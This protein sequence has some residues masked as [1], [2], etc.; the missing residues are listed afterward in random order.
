MKNLKETIYLNKQRALYLV[1][2]FIVFFA[3]YAYCGIKLGETKAFEGINLLFELDCPLVIDDMT[4]P[5]A[6]H[7]RTNVHPLYVIFFNPFGSFLK[8]IVQ[9]KILAATLIN[10]FTG[11]LGVFLTSIFFLFFTKNYFNSLLFGCLFGLSASQFFFGVI[12]ETF[13]ANTVSLILTYLLFFLCLLR[14]KVY[15]LA[16]ILAGVFT[17]GMLITNFIQTL[18]LFVIV[19]F[20][21]YKKKNT[22]LSKTFTIFVYLALVGWICTV[23]AIIQKIL[24]PTSGLFFMAASIKDEFKF[25]KF[26]VFEKP[27]LII[28]QVFRYFFWSNFIAPMPKTKIIG[29]GIVKCVAGGVGDYGYLGWLAS[30]VGSV[31]LVA[32]IREFLKRLKEKEIFYAGIFLCI[33]F[34][35]LL[36][37]FYGI[38]DIYNTSTFIYTA[39]FTFLIFILY[40]SGYICT[41]K[42]L[43]RV[44]LIILAI[45]L[46]MNN[47]VVFSNIVQAFK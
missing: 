15:F 17:F 33:L 14:K 8:N 37:I 12:P 28:S 20:K 45:L 5:Q 24:Y 23:L 21:I 34:N 27:L 41:K 4:A 46:G 42:L 7:Y 31:F 30:F 47:L 32:G 9:S 22:G 11:A 25:L 39:N 44:F 29:S 13:S 43:A 1:L 10:S 3:L 26:D 18:I 6:N 35:F 40:V 19:I 2:I 38:G 16:W 36:H